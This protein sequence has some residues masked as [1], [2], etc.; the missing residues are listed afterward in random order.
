MQANSRV[1]VKSL[2][3][4]QTNHWLSPGLSI[5][6]LSQPQRLHKA[7]VHFHKAHELRHKSNQCL[8]LLTLTM[9]SHLLSLLWLLFSFQSQCF[10]L[11]QNSQ[12]PSKG[13]LQAR[14]HW[15]EPGS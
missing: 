11:V 13:Y 9:H 6:M 10:R 1:C 15:T 5:K 3:P 2:K 7:N 8:T 14:G 12:T 4:S